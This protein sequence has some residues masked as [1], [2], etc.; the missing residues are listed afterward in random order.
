M[1][2][3]I[4]TLFY[5]YCQIQNRTLETQLIKKEIVQI[6]RA[7]LIYFQQIEIFIRDSQNRYQNKLGTMIY[8]QREGIF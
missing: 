5:L 7:I 1:Q 6:L 2:Q 4:T 3:N 8:L